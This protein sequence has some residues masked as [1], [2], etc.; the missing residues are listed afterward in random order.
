[1][2][3]HRADYDAWAAARNPGWTTAELEPLIAHLKE[4]LHVRLYDD[5]EVTPFQRASIDAMIAFGLPR[6]VD[7]N[8][9]DQDLGV[10]QNPVNIVDGVRFN[11]AFGYLDPVR[12][13]P[14]LEIAADALCDRLVAEGGRVTGAVIVRGGR[15]ET[16]A[17]GRVVLC[18]GVYASPAILMRSG[19]GDPAELNR[20]AIRRRR[21]DHAD[22]SRANTHLPGVLVGE[23]IAASLDA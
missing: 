20:H 12:G 8:D 1:M 6:V 11:A 2:I 22:G 15:R 17:A 5:A 3:G 16:I 9:L 7:L 18:A 19:V 21:L 4:R 23:R 10:A 13:R 14:N